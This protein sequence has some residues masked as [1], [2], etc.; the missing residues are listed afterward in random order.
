MCHFTFSTS[1]PIIDRVSKF[2]HW[3]TLQTIYNNAI[4]IYPTTRLM[5]FY[6]NLWNINV[7]KTNDNN[8]NL[9][10]WK[11]HFRPTLRWMICMTL[12]CVMPTQSRVIQTIH[13]NIGLKCCFFNF[14]KMFVCYYR[15]VCTFHWYFTRWY[16][17]TFMVWWGSII[18]T[19]SQIVCRVCQWKNFENRS[20][21]SKIWTKVKWHVFLAHHVHHLGD[22]PFQ[23]VTCT[24]TGRKQQ[25]KSDKANNTNNP[26]NIN[27]LHK[28]MEHN[29]RHNINQT[30]TAGENTHKQYCPTN[31]N[32]SLLFNWQERHREKSL[33]ATPL[34]WQI[35]SQI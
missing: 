27:R 9:G 21:I 19:L 6:T 23:A 10:K 15:Y 8:K 29:N 26:K 4:I 35:Q 7:R 17:D 28:C 32:I 11:K 18:I 13:C 2:F 3:H 22:K 5:H 31:T 33:F 1:L 30:H 24:G 25:Q 16:R 20:I 12:D 34:K 14:I